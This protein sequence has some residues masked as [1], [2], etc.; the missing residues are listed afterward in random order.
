M[1]P[2]SVLAGLR[3]LVVEDEMT[4]SLLIEDILDDEG[5][6]VVGP[7]HRVTNALASAQTDAIDLAVLD[8]N[9]A[10]ERVF[11][12]AETLAA[13]SIPFLLLSGY[14]QNALPPDHLDWMVCSKPFKPEKLVYMLRERFQTRR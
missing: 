6:V 1:A 2:E 13:R 8:V 10:G 12:V 5:C 14:G 11:P 3:V 9:V 7:F 4:I